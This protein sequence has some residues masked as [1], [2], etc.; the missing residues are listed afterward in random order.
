M[1]I[2]ILMTNT[3]ESD[4]A[5]ERPKDGEKWTNLLAPLR[6][7]WEFPVYSVK[8]GEF[9][10]DVS[11]FDG[12]IVTGSP[13][14][15]HDGEPWINRLLEMIRESVSVSVPV[16]GACFGHQAVSVALGGRVE[17]RRAR[18]T[19]SSSSGSSAGIERVATRFGSLDGTW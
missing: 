19:G 11:G 15:V 8:D 17:H 16:F 6:P 7:D 18:S 12:V 4:F 5:Q 3:D 1:Q 13:A 9:P 10:D 14:S 2:A